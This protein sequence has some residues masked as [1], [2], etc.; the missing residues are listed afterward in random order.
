MPK[1]EIKEISATTNTVTGEGGF[2]STDAE[3][4]SSKMNRILLAAETAKSRDKE[5]G[6]VGSRSKVSRNVSAAAPTLRRTDDE[7]EDEEEEVAEEEEM[8]SCGGKLFLA[9]GVEQ[10]GE[11][12]ELSQEEKLIAA[13]TNPDALIKELEE[14]LEENRRLKMLVDEIT[15][16][17][18]VT[19]KQNGDERGSLL[20]CSLT[21]LRESSRMDVNASRTKSPSK[22]LNPS[23]IKGRRTVDL[24]TGEVLE[25]ASFE[26]GYKKEE[27][28]NIQ[29]T[30]FTKTTFHHEDES[31]QQN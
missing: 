28:A 26:N 5:N 2:G 7:D 4:E 9:R 23:R 20:T 3:E 24:E 29:K 31:D 12:A 30:R 8:M 6:K 15:K 1:V 19:G 18:E 27:N 22:D 14:Q 17:E 16:E 11:E 21:N 25:E 10:P 13:S